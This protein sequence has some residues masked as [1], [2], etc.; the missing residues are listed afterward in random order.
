MS[1]KSCP[2]CGSTEV[3]PNRTYC[4]KPC[5]SS[6]R[7]AR[8]KG[9]VCDAPGC[10]LPAASLCQK[11]YKRM[12]TNGT[13]E[14][15]HPWVDQTPQERFEAKVRDGEP[16]ACW[17]WTGETQNKGYGVFRTYANGRAKKHLAHRWALRA[18]G[19]DLR[20]DQVVLHSCDNPPCV[21]PAHLRAGTQRD[22]VLDAKAKGRLNLDG[23][24]IGQ[25]M[26]TRRKRV[27]A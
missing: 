2:I 5:A 13:L 6:S 26:P 24:V 4:S 21:N 17:N 23:L 19:V 20:D 22:N 3:K 27:A 8:H 7:A 18:S 9:R 12:Q 16:D 11:H 14:P 1:D 15:R 25:R 10:T